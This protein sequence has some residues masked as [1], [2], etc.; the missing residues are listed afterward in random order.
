MTSGMESL[1]SLSKEI[2]SQA[3]S[4]PGHACR[5]VIAVAHA[6]HGQPGSG[7]QLLGAG[8]QDA[9]PASSGAMRVLLRPLAL[10]SSCLP[11]AQCSCSGPDMA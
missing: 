2:W 1:P 5:V 3:S 9:P 8:P 4:S 7:H 11:A 6:A 10:W